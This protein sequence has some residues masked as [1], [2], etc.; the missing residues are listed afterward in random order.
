MTGTFTQ[1]CVDFGSS[2]VPKSTQSGL[3]GPVTT[4]GPRN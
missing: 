1:D 3:A 4:G 2:N